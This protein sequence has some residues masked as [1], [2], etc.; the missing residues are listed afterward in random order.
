MFGVHTPSPEHA[1]H[2]DQVP[3]ALSQ[4][5]VCVPHLPHACEAEPVH[6]WFPHAPHVQLPP[7][8][9]VPP[10]PQLCVALGAHAPSPVHADQADQVPALWSHVR[11]WVPQLP[12]ACDADPLQDWLP[13]GVHLQSIPHDCV[14]PLPQARMDAGAHS[15]MHPGLPPEESAAEPSP[16]EASLPLGGGPDASWSS[17][18]S[19][20]PP[21]PR[22]PPASLPS[23]PG[24]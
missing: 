12:H 16:L 17:E 6:V 15:P 14:P 19:P 24:V 18:A 2:A 20:A 13:H 7:H 10:L 21:R 8:D 5:R 4:V 1:D 9:W 22:F 3:L 11:V 23:S